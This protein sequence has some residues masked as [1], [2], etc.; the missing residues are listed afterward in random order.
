MHR[1][2]LYS[3]EKDTPTKT[4]MFTG[5]LYSPLRQFE[6]LLPSGVPITFREGCNINILTYFYKWN[7]E[8]RGNISKHAKIFFCIFFIFFVKD[9][10]WIIIER[11]NFLQIFILKPP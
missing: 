8:F 3:T 7:L 1:V 6:S 5:Y 9:F 2:N 10:F 11:H 4:I